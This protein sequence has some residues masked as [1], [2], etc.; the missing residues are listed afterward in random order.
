MKTRYYTD[1]TETFYYNIKIGDLCKADEISLDGCEVI[2][3]S[4]LYYGAKNYMHELRVLENRAKKISNDVFAKSLIETEIF[5]KRLAIQQVVRSNVTSLLN[6]GYIELEFDVQDVFDA[7]KYLKDKKDFKGQVNLCVLKQEA[8]KDGS[9]GV[10]FDKGT[11][12]IQDEAILKSYLTKY[13]SE[14]EDLEERLAI[15]NDMI[16]S[17]GFALRCTYKVDELADGGVRVYGALDLV[18]AGI[19]YNDPLDFEVYNQVYL[20]LKMFLQQCKSCYLI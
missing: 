4:S 10:V 9:V 18:Y 8:V 13:I 19:D 3:N 17:L 15:V 5:N 2:K 14:Y 20:A 12:K 11:P 6:K 16:R 7:W 1:F